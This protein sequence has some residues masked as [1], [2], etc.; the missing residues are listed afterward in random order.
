MVGATTARDPAGFMVPFT[1]IPLRFKTC[2]FQDFWDAERQTLGPWMMIYYCSKY[3]S[4]QKNGFP[5]ESGSCSHLLEERIPVT[6]GF[7]R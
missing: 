3:L 2:F 7:N 1:K 5:P 4:L 6:E